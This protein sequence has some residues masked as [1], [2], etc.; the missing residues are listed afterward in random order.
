MSLAIRWLKPSH[1]SMLVLKFSPTGL[2]R[3]IQTGKSVASDFNYYYPFLLDD[4]RSKACCIILKQNM[5]H[6]KIT[7]FLVM[8]FIYC[9]RYSTTS[10]YKPKKIAS[11]IAL[12]ANRNAAKMAKQ[13][14]NCPALGGI[15]TNKFTL[16]IQL[17]VKSNN[18]N[19]SFFFTKSERI[20]R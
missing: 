5:S 12:G 16:L 1:K 11:P 13:D 14:H 6:S 19:W 10:K 8:G 2:A 4:Q 9:F 3:I 7:Q 20:R 17:I 18:V 15:C